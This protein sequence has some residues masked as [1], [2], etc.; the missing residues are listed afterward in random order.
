MNKTTIIITLSVLV[1]MLGYYGYASFIGGGEEVVERVKESGQTQAPVSGTLVDEQEKNKRRAEKK[2]EKQYPSDVAESV[3]QNAIHHM[4]HSMV[5]ADKK[6]GHLEPSQ[7]RI[8]RLLDV[9]DQNQ[10]SYEQASL[11]ITILERW[12]RG[13]YSHAVSDHNQMWN[14]QGGTVGKATRLLSNDEVNSYR[15]KHFE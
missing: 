10:S 8:E 4:S 1:L 9:L 12:Q 15:K 2:M 6:W 3:I 11:Y 13:D 5:H 14:L 7:E